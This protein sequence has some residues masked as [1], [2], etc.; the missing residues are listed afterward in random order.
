V[1]VPERIIFRAVVA[2]LFSAWLLPAG[3]AKAQASRDVLAD[4]ESVVLAGVLRNGGPRFEIHLN[5]VPFHKPG[6]SPSPAPSTR[7]LG[8]DGQ[9]PFCTVVSFAL[10]LD[11]VETEIPRRSYVDLADVALPRGIYITKRGPLIVVHV[12]GGDGAGSYKASF[13]FRGTRLV[14]R[15]VEQLNESGKPTVT[16]TRY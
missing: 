3:L 10:S 7:F 5:C 9:D 4:Y 6:N 12:Q 14:S 11:G 1:A 8:T 2:T 16:Q 15:E 13:L